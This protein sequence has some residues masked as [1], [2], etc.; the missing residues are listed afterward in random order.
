DSLKT[1]DS[2]FTPAVGLVRGLAKSLARLRSEGLE[3]CW[4]RCAQLAR[5]AR[6]GLTAVGLQL[7]AKSP[8]EVMTVACVP[9]GLDGNALL[10]HLEAWYGVKLAGGQDS[11]KGK[12]LRLAHM[13]YIDAFDILA[14][15]SALEMTLARMGWPVSPGTAVAAAQHVFQHTP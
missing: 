13:G 3:T 8:A 12:I 1:N 7:F 2:P 5:M 11:L 10:N 6:A 9:E 14:V 4:A 15:L